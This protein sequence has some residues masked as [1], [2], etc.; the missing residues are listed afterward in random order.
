[1]AGAICR[2]QSVRFHLL[3]AAGCRPAWPGN[4]RAWRAG[5][6]TARWGCSYVCGPGWEP[7]A[8]RP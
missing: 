4:I 6:R 7:G 1:L 5:W 3:P 8:D 2:V